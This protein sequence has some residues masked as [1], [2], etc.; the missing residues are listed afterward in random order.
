[1]EDKMN[2][3]YIKNSLLESFLEN[4]ELTQSDFK[5]IYNKICYIY[6]QE[7]VQWKE[8]CDKLEKDNMRMKKI[9]DSDISS[10]IRSGFEKMQNMVVNGGQIPHMFSIVID[11]NN[12]QTGDLN[13]R[14]NTDKIRQENIF[15]DN[16]KKQIM[17]ETNDE[18]DRMRTENLKKIFIENMNNDKN[19]FFISNSI[20]KPNDNN[21]NKKYKIYNPY[22]NEGNNSIIN[23]SSI[24]NKKIDDNSNDNIKIEKEDDIVDKMLKK[25]EKSLELA[26]LFDKTMKIVNDKTKD[27]SDLFNLWKENRDVVKSFMETKDYTMINKKINSIFYNPTLES[28]LKKQRIEYHLQNFLFQKYLFKC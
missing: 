28:V 2:Y 9:M 4:R 6:E 16:L 15:L 3:S 11:P 14:N 12:T 7:I 18:A 17:K 5:Q 24:L 10:S 27:S 13:A 19:S 21:D 23:T 25:N 1:M 8:K 22:E 20:L 26:N